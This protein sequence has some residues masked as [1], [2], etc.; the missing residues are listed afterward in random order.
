MK[1]SDKSALKLIQQILARKRVT[2]IIRNDK[3]GKNVS[4]S[5]KNKSKK[6]QNNLEDSILNQ[7]LDPTLLQDCT[8]I[9][10]SSVLRAID[11]LSNLDLDDNNI[12]ICMKGSKSERDIFWNSPTLILRSIK[13][14][15]LQRN[16]DDIVY[17][18]M[19]LLQHKDCYIPVVEQIC[20]FIRRFH[21]A[22]RKLNLQWQFEMLS[23]RGK[24]VEMEIDD[25]DEINI[26]KVENV[27]NET[28][29]IKEQTSE[30]SQLIL[31]TVDNV[32]LE[33]VPYERQEQI[34]LFL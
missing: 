31:N 18:L 9:S 6:V 28:D 7:G 2:K 17:F 19:I 21:P 32:I 10:L 11:N 27:K 14:C 16:W 3:I 13:Y 1:T 22:V 24:K 34:C 5:I 15:I 26:T 20:G 30:D 12:K 4:K 8:E 33:D 29:E 25:L 23:L